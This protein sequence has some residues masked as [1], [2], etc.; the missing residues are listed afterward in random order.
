VQNNAKRA[1]KPRPPAPTISTVPYSKDI[2]CISYRWANIEAGLVFRSERLMKSVLR[3][4]RYL[5]TWMLTAVSVVC[6]TGCSEDPALSSAS[7]VIV[8][9]QE[10]RTPDNLFHGLPNADIADVGINSQGKTISLAPVPLALPYDLNHSHQAFLAMWD[11]GKMDGADKVT[12]ACPPGVVKCWP[13][14]P[15]FVYV[16][17]SQVKPYFDLATQYVF[18]DRM[19]QTHQGPSFP[20]HQFIIAGTSAPTPTSD[21]FAAEN[22]FH[23]RETTAKN[24]FSSSGCTASNLWV[25]MIDPAGSESQTHVTCFE[26]STLMDLLDARH[27]SWRYYSV[28]DSWNV[29][30]NGPSAIRHLR[31]G[32]DWANV[33][34]QNTEILTD[35]RERPSSYRE[36]GNSI[37]T[38]VRSSCRQRR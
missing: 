27:L 32:R 15:Q 31:F 7:H 21:L 38:R 19:F 4:V 5:A 13:P 22:P 9:V 6:S 29:L 26:H 33:T 24:G 11:Q 34:A 37:R 3:N 10:N 20:A 8:I 36:L 23:L 30:W 25:N 35:N 28:G 2:L 16:D 1:H 17:P 14:N 18:A 12:I